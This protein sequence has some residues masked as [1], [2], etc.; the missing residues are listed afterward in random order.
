MEHMGLGIMDFLSLVNHMSL[1]NSLSLVNSHRW[2]L[3]VCLVSTDKA[4]FF[5][6]D[7]LEVAWQDFVLMLPLLEDLKLL[8]AQPGPLRDSHFARF[9]PRVA[10]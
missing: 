1:V 7:I 6:L 5:G 8:T 3:S 10:A 9:L 2:S 4:S